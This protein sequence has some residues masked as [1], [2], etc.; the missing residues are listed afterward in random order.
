M[1]LDE[2]ERRMLQER[3][4]GRV[5]VVVHKAA[6]CTEIE[7]SGHGNECGLQITRNKIVR[8]EEGGDNGTG[9][10]RESVES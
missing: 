6:W 9:C 2:S 4:K 1:K 10:V 3:K 5:V 7:K 8:D